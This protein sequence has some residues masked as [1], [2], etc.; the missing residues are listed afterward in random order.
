MRRAFSLLLAASFFWAWQSC[1][2]AQ[3]TPLTTLPKAF[4][5]AG[6]ETFTVQIADT[7]EAHAVGLMFRSDLPEEEG[8]LFVYDQPRR[9]CMWM[10]NTLIPLSAAFLDADGAILN[11]EDMEPQTTLGHCSN[12]PVLYVLEMNQG[13]FARHGVRAGGRIDLSR[14]PR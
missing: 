6:G 13:W 10:K 5:S 4:L 14:L 11:L 12:G 9:R 2:S 8:M 3:D 1:A 7:S